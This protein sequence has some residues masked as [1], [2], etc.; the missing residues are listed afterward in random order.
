M[1]VHCLGAPSK[2]ALYFRF[3]MGDILY[4]SSYIAQPD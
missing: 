4:V 2:A 3:C 1:G